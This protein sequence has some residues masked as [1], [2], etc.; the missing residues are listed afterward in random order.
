MPFLVYHINYYHKTISIKINVK[1]SLVFD[2]K[3]KLH[4]SFRTIHYTELLVAD[5]TWKLHNYIVTK[6]W[7]GAVV[8]M[9]KVIHRSDL[10]YSFAEFYTSIKLEAQLVIINDCLKDGTICLYYYTITKIIE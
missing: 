6:C 7:S 9:C 10:N 4:S 8:R 5:V 3:S 1:V 2:A